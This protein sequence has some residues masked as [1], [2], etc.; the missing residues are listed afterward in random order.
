MEMWEKRARSL[1]EVNSYADLFSSA[2]YQFLHQE[3]VSVSALSRLLKAVAKSVRHTNAL[4]T[5]L[6]IELLQARGHS[7]IAS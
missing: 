3:S 6:A 4:F 5:I 1:V 7:A 2:A